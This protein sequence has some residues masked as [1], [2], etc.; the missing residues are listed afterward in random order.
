MREENYFVKKLEMA[1]ESIIFAKSKLDHLD[2]QINVLN[3]RFEHDKKVYNDQ[4]KHMQEIIADMEKRIPEYEKKIAQGYVAVDMRTGKAYKSFNE[5]QTGI[6]K[7]KIKASEEAQKAR[8]AI[9]TEKR[10]RK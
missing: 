5:R 2:V 7:D 4:A 3:V 10:E 8:K 9:E 1:K 6:L